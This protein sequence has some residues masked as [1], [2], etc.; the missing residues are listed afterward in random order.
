MH[1]AVHQNQQ[2][3]LLHHSMRLLPTRVMLPSTSMVCRQQRARQPVFF[4]VS[5]LHPQQHAAVQAQL[6][7]IHAQLHGG[8]GRRA[9]HLQQTCQQ[10]GQRQR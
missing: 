10:Q 3:V 6:D 1:A 7:V 9:Q 5:V 4:P 8:L 2:A